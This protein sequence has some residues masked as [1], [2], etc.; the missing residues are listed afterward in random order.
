MGR[1]AK[2]EG[3]IARAGKSPNNW[4]I[5][6]SRNVPDPVTGKKKQVRDKYRFVG[7]KEEANKERIRL[8]NQK[9]NGTYVE[10]S[11]ILFGEWAVKWLE[12]II[13]PQKGDRTYETYK[14]VI[15][16]HLI[17]ELGA[18]PLQK[19][20]AMDIQGYYNR[21]SQ[22]KGR[23]RKKLAPATL[24]QHHTVIHGILKAAESFGYVAKNAAKQ[25]PAKPHAKRYQDVLEHTWT[26]AEANRFL[27]TVK[28]KAVHSNWLFTH[29]HSTQAPGKLNC[30][31]CSGRMWILN[32]A[33]S[34]FISN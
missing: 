26:P 14:D 27:K 7:T 2:G 20:G 4:Y 18:I 25:V 21:K 1:K 28:E 29:W 22:G 17:P 8:L 31:G 11:K 10:P 13:K 9:N 3:C 23:D 19:L 30:A 24:E 6:L 12:E 5:I 33:R 15:E 32:K 34:S 16:N